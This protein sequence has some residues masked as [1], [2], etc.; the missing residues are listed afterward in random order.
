MDIDSALIS[1]LILTYPCILQRLMYSTFDFLSTERHVCWHFSWLQLFG[2]LQVEVMA[3]AVAASP[4]C[5]WLIA[6]CV[7]RT[8]A[9]LS[10]DDGPVSSGP[11]GRRLR[12][13]VARSKQLVAESWFPN[14]GIGMQAGSLSGQ[15]LVAFCESGLSELGTFC[16]LEGCPEYNNLKHEPLFRDG[17]FGEGLAGLGGLGSRPMRTGRSHRRAA[18]GE[19]LIVVQLLEHFL[20]LS[21][22]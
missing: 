18:A 6:A 14:V 15:S 20:F 22:A 21:R 2:I 11:L 3:F 13:R 8:V 19:I 1:N 7:S 4:L 17:F 12:R 16:S 9:G 5:T 10:G